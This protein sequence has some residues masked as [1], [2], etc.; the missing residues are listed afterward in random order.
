MKTNPAARFW[1]FVVPV[2]DCWEWTGAISPQGYG[3]FGW[4]MSDVR[5]AHR[6]AWALTNGPIPADMHVLHRCDNRPCVRP[7][8]LFL[9]TNRDNVDDKM[10]KGRQSRGE[11]HGRAKL[12]APEALAIRVWRIA[13]YPVARL[14]EMFGVSEASVSVIANRKKWAH[15]DAEFDIP[16]DPYLEEKA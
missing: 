12:T 11:T 5:M 16:V 1:S 3:R 7:S 14:A 9:G 8:H 10:A 2:G 15:L 13:G 4:A 6:V